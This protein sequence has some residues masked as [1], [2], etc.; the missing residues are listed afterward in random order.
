M[1]RFSVIQI[2]TGARETIEG[3]PADVKAMIEMGLI[4]DVT[5]C[6]AMPLTSPTA[7]P[8]VGHVAD[9]SAAL[10]PSTPKQGLVVNNAQG[11]TVNVTGTGRTDL[12]KDKKKGLKPLDLSKIKDDRPVLWNANGTKAFS[13]RKVIAREFERLDGATN[14]SVNIKVL[15]AAA[16]GAI[17][18]SMLA[19]KE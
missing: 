10:T 4:K 6:T 13:A 12:T 15:V 18:G 16:A 17:G 3:T 1:L 8:A 11:G 9:P 7:A 19:A 5:V 2:A 14:K